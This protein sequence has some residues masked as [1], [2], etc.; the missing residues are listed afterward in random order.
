MWSR[1]DEVVVG[2]WACE[3]II[4]V[5][6][7]A[8]ITKRELLVALLDSGLPRACLI[9]IVSRGPSFGTLAQRARI[10]QMLVCA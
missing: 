10:L 1:Y 6:V 8:M 7:S 5:C 9:V 2:V 3:G 4:W